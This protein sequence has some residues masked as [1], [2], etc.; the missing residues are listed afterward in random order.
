MVE[1]QPEE[2]KLQVAVMDMQNDSPKALSSR[3]KLCFPFLST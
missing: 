2:Q 1:G 3:K